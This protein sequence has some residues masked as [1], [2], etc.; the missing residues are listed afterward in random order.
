MLGRGHNAKAER[1]ASLWRDAAV[2]NDE[3][4]GKGVGGQA[5]ELVGMWR[6]SVRKR[7][8]FDQRAQVLSLVSNGVV[9]YII[10]LDYRAQI[11]LCVCEQSVS[12][13]GQSTPV[14]ERGAK[15]I[16]G[17]GRVADD[18]AKYRPPAHFGVAKVI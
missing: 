9:F 6:A 16:C 7:G 8:G 3:S 17:S 15:R 1:P 4:M 13:P 5:V 12:S 14:P 11:T 10:S 18:D 2:L